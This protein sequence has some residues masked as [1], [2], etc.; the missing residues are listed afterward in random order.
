MIDYLDLRAV[1]PVN[2]RINRDFENMGNQVGMVLM[3]L[4]VGLGNQQNRYQVVKLRMDDLKQSGESDTVFNLLNTPLFKAKLLAPVMVGVITPKASLLVTNV[5]G[6]QEPIILAGRKI[7][8]AIFWIPQPAGWGLGISIISYAG[9]ITL[10]VA[11]D[12]HLIPDPNQ[13]LE[14]IEAEFE[15]MYELAAKEPDSQ[16]A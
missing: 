5:P 8:H 12:A 6:P 15:A 14:G 1:V 16:K 13:I 11:V 2:I 3:S 7:R 10:G 4:P 9:E